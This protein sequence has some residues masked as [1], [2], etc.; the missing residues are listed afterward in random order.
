MVHIGGNRQ[1]LLQRQLA[2]IISEVIGDHCSGSHRNI[3]FNSYRRLLFWRQSVIVIT[4]AAI[5]VYYFGGDWQSL[6]E[7]F[8]RPNGRVVKTVVQM[9]KRIVFVLEDYV[10]GEWLTEYYT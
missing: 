6:A 1:S 8:A 3:Y 9:S 10:H 5:G 2:I 7:S 4:S